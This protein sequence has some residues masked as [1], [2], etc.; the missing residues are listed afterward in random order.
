MNNQVN[1]PVIDHDPITGQPIEPQLSEEMMQKALQEQA[2]E[3]QQAM[4]QQ[5]MQQQQYYQQ[6]YYQQQYNQQQY[7]QQ[8]NQQQYNQQQYYQ[9]NGNASQSNDH[10]QLEYARQALEYSMA[11]EK[12]KMEYDNTNIRCRIICWASLICWIIRRIASIDLVSTFW[13]SFTG[14]SSNHIYFGG[15]VLS[16][17]F[18]L[19]GLAAYVLMIYAR[20][21]YPKSKFAKVLMWI[22]IIEI[23]ITVLLVV[24]AIFYFIGFLREILIH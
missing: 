23:S 21:K 14:Y 3:Q 10:D 1:K 24:L 4:Q 13:G 22:Y 16:R 2:M 11:M 12:Q 20:V 8:Y 17:L 19:I 18:Q 9:Q 7:N 6:Q 15:N 5:A